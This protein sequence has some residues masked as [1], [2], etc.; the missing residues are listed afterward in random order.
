MNPILK[1]L[2]TE[3][4]ILKKKEENNFESLIKLLEIP[5]GKRTYEN[6]KEISFFLSV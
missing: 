5:K 6:L 4:Y 3:N 2:F 1:S